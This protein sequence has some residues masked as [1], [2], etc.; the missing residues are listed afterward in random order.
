MGAVLSLQGDR[1]VVMYSDAN[2]APSSAFAGS[3]MFGHANGHPHTANHNHSR[4]SHQGGKSFF[5]HAS[6]ENSKH[7]KFGHGLFGGNHNHHQPSSGPNGTHFP[8]HNHPPLS[9]MNAAGPNND[10]IGSQ[11]FHGN[12]HHGLKK[13]LGF[14]NALHLG[15]HFGFGKEKKNKLN[16]HDLSGQQSLNNTTKVLNQRE[17]DKCNAGSSVPLRNGIQKSLS[18][19]NLKSGTT[20]SN[21]E[22]VKNINKN[23]NDHEAEDRNNNGIGAKNIALASKKDSAEPTASRREIVVHPK[24]EDSFM[25]CGRKP[26][27]LTTEQF[28]VGKIDVNESQSKP[29]IFLSKTSQMRPNVYNVLQQAYAGGINNNGQI[30]LPNGNHATS[31]VG[32]NAGF[33]RKTSNVSLGS[34]NSSNG[35]FSDVPNML[36]QKRTVIQVSALGY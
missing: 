23:I 36:G 27:L 18:C 3:K 6:K 4:P 11:A 28:P 35:T 15:K 9:E 7:F 29:I 30:I 32:P 8:Q 31:I 16:K 20:T 24:K 26:V 22:I 14:I 2:I 33:T 12:H 5:G 25:Y 34:T 10:C 17:E 19:Y 21:I 13:S 1:K